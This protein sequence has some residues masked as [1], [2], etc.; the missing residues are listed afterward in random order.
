MNRYQQVNDKKSGRS[1]IPVVII[2][3]SLAGVAWFYTEY[4]QHSAVSGAKTQALELPLVT[5]AIDPLANNDVS[6]IDEMTTTEAGIDNIIELQQ[7]NLF[8]LPDLEHSDALLR[9]EIEG[10][11]PA[12]SEW[13]NVDQLIRAYVVIANDFSQELRLEKHLRFLK[14]EQAFT[15]DPNH[16]SSF[17]AMK[18]YRRYDRLAAAI[19]GMDVQAT[20][21]VYKKFRPLLLQVFSEFSYPVEYRLDDIL[22]KAAA[23]ILA[24]PVVDGQIAVVKHAVNY[25]FADPQLEALSPIHKQML[26]MGPENTRII[27]HKLRSL[28][29]GLVN[30][31]E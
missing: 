12:F 6:I 5:D 3:I 19:N 23:V 29:E 2:L 13:L 14:M 28:V 4:Q 24:A 10:I 18:S 15:V 20:L 21:T 8:V 9:Q 22:T 7:D 30:L 31:K 17:I 25:K 11:S 16:E 27:Q 26:R 1:V